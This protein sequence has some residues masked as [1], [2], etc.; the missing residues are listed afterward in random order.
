[1]ALQQLKRW[2]ESRRS[3]EASIDYWQQVGNVAEQVNTLDNLGLLYLDQKQH[4][5]A[6]RT[7]QRAACMVE[8]LEGGELRTEL[9]EMVAEHLS[10]ATL[11][12]TVS[13]PG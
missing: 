1:M 13:E 11:G 5:A 8:Q 2:D 3:Y 10:Q 9:Q 4:D 7:F 12:R 6:I